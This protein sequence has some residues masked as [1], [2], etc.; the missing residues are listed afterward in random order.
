MNVPKLLRTTLFSLLALVLAG[1]LSAA[2]AQDTIIVDE[3]DP[4]NPD[5]ITDGVSQVDEDGDVVAIRAGGY[6]DASDNIITVSTG[7]DFVIEARE[8]DDSGA[9]SVN[10]ED[11]TFDDA[12]QTVTLR[13]DGVGFHRIDGSST[14][15]LQN[16][17]VSIEAS[18]DVQLRDG[19]TVVRRSGSSISGSSLTFLGDANLAYDLQ[20]GDITA[21][22]EAPTDLGGT[23]TIEDGRAT[24]NQP[25]QTV[26]FPSGRFSTFSTD[27]LN[28]S[29]NDDV[30]AEFDGDLN[31]ANGFAVGSDQSLEVAGTLELTD[32]RT[33]Q[34]LT[35][36]S[37]ATNNNDQVSVGDLVLNKAPRNAPTLLSGSGQLVV[38]GTTTLQIVSNSDGNFDRV[39]ETIEAF[40]GNQNPGDF[41]LGTL[42]ETAV[43]DGD[44]SDLTTID[45][46]NSGGGTVT[47]GGGGFRKLNNAGAQSTFEVRGDVT[48]DVSSG[49]VGQ[50]GPSPTTF[51]I[52]N[53][54]NGATINVSSGNTLTVD[55]S[56]PQ[57]SGPTVDHDNS[58]T[59]GISG[60]GTI[61]F[62]NGRGERQEVDV[63]DTNTD[64]TD[65]I[66][67]LP[68]VVVAGGN[69]AEFSGT[70]TPTGNQTESDGSAI[71]IGGGLT[72]N[73]SVDLTSSDGGVRV[74]GATTVNAGT[75]DLTG[76]ADAVSTGDAILNNAG[77]L[78]VDDPNVPTTGNVLRIRRDFE[79]A[80]PDAELTTNSSTVAFTSGGTDG[81]FNTQARFTI[82]GTVRV[83][84]PN[85]TITLNE[86]VTVNGDFEILD[87]GQFLSSTLRLEDNLFLTGNGLL[88]IN[89]NLETEEG[90]AIVF[91][92]AYQVAGSDTLGNAIV[93]GGSD[94]RVDNPN[95]NGSL[96]FDG[97]LE[98]RDGGVRITADE[99]LSPTGPDAE[100]IRTLDENDGQQ[101]DAT[102][103]Q[104]TT[105]NG[106]GNEY[107]LTY[108]RDPNSPSGA[109][110]ADETA[111]EL[112]D[113]VDN[114]TVRS[115][116]VPKLDRDVEVNGSL[117]VAQSGRIS[118]DDP[119][120][121][122]TIDLVSDGTSH[123]ING[124]IEGG[125]VGG[126]GTINPVTLDVAAEGVTVIG[127]DGDANPFDSVLENVTISEAGATISGVQ[128]IRGTL[129]VDGGDLE[130]ALRN[131]GT[132][133][134]Q[135]VQGAITVNDSLSLAADAE[136]TASSG[137]D[138]I[139][140][141]SSGRLNVRTR[142]FLVT[143]NGMD[144]N[145]D[146][147]A[148][149]Y[150][151]GQEGIVRFN[152]GGSP[153]VS[154]SGEAVP[155]VELDQSIQLDG[156]VATDV[157]LDADAGIALG[158]N[159]FDFSG[160]AELAANVTG[161]GVFRAQG[162]TLRVDG[163]TRQ[164]SNFEVD[165]DTS[166]VDLVNDTGDPV[167]P[168]RGLQV[169]NTFTMTSGTLN[170]SASMSLTGSLGPPGNVDEFIY[171]GGDFEITTAGVRGAPYI[172][173][174]S[175]GSGNPGNTVASFSIAQDST[176]SIP[177]LGIRDDAELSSPQ[178]LIITNN[179]RL[180]DNFN[181]ASQNGRLVLADG[182]TIDRR[183]PSLGA[184]GDT[185]PNEDILDEA[186]AFQSSE[187][188]YNLEYRGGGQAITSGRE[189]SGDPSRIGRLTIGRPGGDVFFES[190]P[191]V[192]TGD[193]TVNG[194]L[195]LSAGVLDYGRQ[196][197]VADS[198]TVVRSDGELSD[199]PDTNTPDSDNGS[200]DGG[201]GGNPAPIEAPGF[202]TLVYDGTG[203]RNATS[204]EFLGDGDVAL[205]TRVGTPPSSP[206]GPTSGTVR[207]P[208]SRTVTTLSVQNQTER[209]DQTGSS[210]TEIGS[211]TDGAQVLTVTDS[212]S[213]SGG[214]LGTTS[215][216]SQRPTLGDRVVVEG[217]LTMTGGTVSVGVDI[218]GNTLVADGGFTGSM[219]TEGDV[220]IEPNGNFGAGTLRF[221]GTEQD[222][223]LDGGP[224]TV[225][226]LGLA[227]QNGGDGRVFLTGDE[228]R[229]GG[230]INFDA[231]LMVVPDSVNQ[232]EVLVEL[233][234]VTRGGNSPGSN[235]PF[236][237][238]DVDDS[239]PSDQSHI[240]GRVRVGV[241]AG[242][243]AT[244]RGT[245]RGRFEF[246]V[247]TE[248]EYRPAAFT[249]RTDDQTE[250][251]TDIVV[252][253]VP[254][255]PEGTEGL[256]L[257]AGTDDQGNP[258]TIGENYPDQY[259][260]V[261][262]ST[263]L[264]PSQELDAEFETGTASFVEQFEDASQ[265]RLIRRF[266]G[267]AQ[268]NQWRLQ[269]SEADDSG[270]DYDNTLI[271]RDDSEFTQVRSQNSTGGISPSG[272]LYT[273]GV[274]T[275]VETD[276][277]SIAGS[278]TYPT[279]SD[280]ELVEGRSLSGV[281]V[282]ASSADT[283][284]TDTTDA[285]G[286]YTISG[287]SAGDYDVT[288]VVSDSVENVS[289]AD[290]L[291]TV[292]GFAGIDPFVGAFQEQVA[293]VD[294]DGDV[295]ATDALLIAQFVLGNV[296][297]FDVGA[298]VTESASVSIE[299]ESAADVSLFAAEAGDVRLD[300]GESEGGAAALASSTISPKTGAGTAATQSSGSSASASAEAG[301]TFE[302]PVQVDRNATVGSYQL[303]VDF[304][305]E[306]ASFEGIK[307]AA[308][309]VL[310]NASED[311]T[312]KVSWFD[313][314]GESALDLR[315]GSDLVT[316]RFKAAK[317][318]E[319][320]EFAPEVI[321]GEIT[322]ADATTLSAGVEVQAVRIGA[323]T[324]DE[325]ALN[326]NY[327][328]P[329]R[330]QATIDMDLPSRTDVTIEVYNVLGQRVQTMERT[331]SAG[332]G[333]TIQ[334]D[335]SKLS[336]G[337]YFYRVKANFEGETARET[338]RITV[339]K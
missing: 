292:R 305:S 23:L 111:D 331:M 157:L 114:L 130:L 306:K 67:A 151:G 74:G 185:N 110:D 259:W 83:N 13:S 164:V 310:T 274:P 308:Q 320:V 288:A 150:S 283:T 52:D 38:D 43:S 208:F 272:A 100:V 303:T 290:A 28:F 333:Q 176:L 184:A 3:D 139:V 327:P 191:D 226:T 311:G 68:G 196:V 131:V 321:S 77:Q 248:S 84:K 253:H 165:S 204:R 240:V 323:P 207:L 45:I 205:V 312:V 299:G 171:D 60:G 177:N 194:S 330:S 261:E 172:F 146:S 105:F 328:N 215:R 102:A 75:V 209:Q 76:V 199:V 163:Q 173:L 263:G 223:L 42:E 221:D 21:G 122:R 32:T 159:D 218:A 106:D 300:G 36:D 195:G 72:A 15:T 200:A 126:G 203:T 95:S 54:A 4:N 140:V 252:G 211:N 301:K 19:A 154:T 228:L 197:V 161:G 121:G 37:D 109:T 59:G 265:L 285:D 55:H 167:M 210:T 296:D 219:A 242:T 115:L 51:P 212:V 152:A 267:D 247:G 315:D 336:S 141:T 18:R 35:V 94:L 142:E 187:A 112:T 202:Y 168:S 266:S 332:A 309:N 319:G 125:A 123:T 293:D 87:P 217:S 160:R 103:N 14:L 236:D 166:T 39:V 241:P 10:F 56:I 222:L 281:A 25:G 156:D 198:A 16:G 257:D 249:F 153:T 155:R 169:T 69:G 201:Q 128:Q 47:V 192:V 104:S 181:T 179:L 276:V 224:S 282:E 337:Q 143:G 46:D 64:G 250:V 243:P 5:T 279:V 302:V 26:D 255:N 287:L 17:T 297:G 133:N 127:G 316:L 57:G 246:P 206:S 237:R 61:R 53:G 66:N 33:S 232:D 268:E 91:E 244:F 120:A 27:N 234:S 186:P 145:G 78:L 101:I 80:S 182:A 89:S 335:G 148:E 79:R 264:G 70:F 251:D 339:V 284:V 20:D 82:D 71:S 291:R 313:Q 96:E 119:D 58:D 239:D 93:R 225:G 245:N 1:G 12:G 108:Q 170:Q 269:A 97:S 258:V 124:R 147:G 262:A 113:N 132:A 137:T 322:G 92:S 44:T 41:D 8:D 144:F 298:F 134:D 235:I 85:A 73:A 138:D 314:G 334:L 29:G 2:Q 317:D 188:T 9:E 50:P 213:V 107:D 31:V 271:Q 129:D 149:Y 231:G 180:I 88:T 338:G 254:M 190:N 273:V 318:V 40:D 294:G 118:D 158:G 230:Q 278:V 86:A 117:T 49:T 63:T 307:G 98:L 193:V 99:D 135:Q 275:E 24:A 116:A 178:N 227:Q 65:D 295:N 329:V 30:V 286:N 62:E 220:V 81:Q 326:G 22:L 324:P 6:T 280:G 34:T 238:S 256:P 270:D 233:S 189:L 175:G 183:A 174:R 260:Y 11:L 304:P 48:V 90:E 214:E 229:V 325:F 289:T 162:A 216:Q 277:F 7:F 136:A